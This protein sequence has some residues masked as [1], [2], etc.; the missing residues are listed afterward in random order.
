MPRLYAARRQMEAAGMDQPSIEE[1]LDQL[2]DE[3]HQERK[4]RELEERMQDL[5]RSLQRDGYDLDALER[6]NPYNQWMYA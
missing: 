1:R 5:E 6:D 4:D 3:Q 2:A